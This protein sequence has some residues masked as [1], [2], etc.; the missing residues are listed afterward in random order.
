VFGWGLGHPGC[1]IVY[2][3]FRRGCFVCLKL[4]HLLVIS[5]KL[6]LVC[7]L[8]CVLVAHIFSSL[9]YLQQLTHPISYFKL[10]SIKNAVYSTKQCFAWPYARSAGHSPMMK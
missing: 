8:F 5:A 9:G 1:F 3:S 4:A 10:Y 2:F 6:G 7:V